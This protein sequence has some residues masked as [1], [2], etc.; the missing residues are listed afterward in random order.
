MLRRLRDQWRERFDGRD[1]ARLECAAAM[2]AIQVDRQPGR[3]VR[4]HRQ[5]EAIGYVGAGVA[6]RAIR[7]VTDLVAGLL[8]QQHVAAVRAA[9]G[10]RD[11]RLVAVE[12][13]EMS[14]VG[15]GDIAQVAAATMIGDR[16]GARPVA[17]LVREDRALRDGQRVVE[18]LQD[19]RG[20]RVRLAAA[21]RGDETCRAGHVQLPAGVRSLETP[22]AHDAGG[23]GDPAI[24]IGGA[25]GGS[26]GMPA[27][28]ND[29]GRA[30]F[31]VS[32]NAAGKEKRP[33]KRCLS[34]LYVLVPEIGVEPTTF[35]LRMR[36]ST[37]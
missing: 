36:C 7:V 4:L 26:R 6:G 14:R 5:R 19:F 3:V 9:T 30:R 15:I 24:V 28:G 33:D 22:G 2:R 18:Q 29:G 21:E 1:L 12:R 8:M 13:I 11:D 27:S 23:R 32:E 34:G 31:R 25:R 17:E 16:H 10:G 37:N 20:E 35:A